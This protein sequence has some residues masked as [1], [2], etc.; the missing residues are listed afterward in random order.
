MMLKRTTAIVLL[1]MLQV[2]GALAAMY[3]TPSERDG[4]IQTVDYNEQDV[5]NVRV[6]AGA[7]TTIKF[8]QDE[9]IK[10]VGIG[11]PEAWSVSVRDNTLFLRPKAEE[12]DTNVTVQTNKHIYP[13][14]LISTTKQPTYILRFN[15]PKPPSATVMTEKPFPCTDGG[16]INGHYQL[17][18][19]KSIFPYQAWDNGEFTCMRWT[20]KQ[21][22][23]VLYRVD[24]DGNEHLVNGDRNKNTM[25]YYDVAENLRLRLGDQVADIRTSS[26]VNRPWN[27]KGTSNGKTRVE[28]FSYEK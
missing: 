20:N 25:V 28:K 21:E 27:K 8:G 23:P 19:D 3:G 1:S 2:P 4:R 24:A 26:I 15:Y 13:L 7:Q 6:K 22:I 12:P 18:G 5:F 11:D 14:Y 16:I 9:T 17:K 10:D